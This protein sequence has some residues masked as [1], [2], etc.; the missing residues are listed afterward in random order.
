MEKM[1]ELL[2]AHFQGPPKNGCYFFF[3]FLFFLHLARGCSKKNILIGFFVHPSKASSD[4]MQQQSSKTKTPPKKGAQFFFSET[5]FFD[6]KQ[7]SKT[8]ILPH[9]LKT[10]HKKTQKKTYFSTFTVAKLLTLKWPKCGQVIDPT[11]YIYI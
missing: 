11:T 7:L 2:P 3:I 10:V 8:L 9:P 6:Q 4:I 5:S 1:V